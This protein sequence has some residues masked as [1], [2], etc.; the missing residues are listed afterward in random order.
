M[1]WT[2]RKKSNSRG[3]PSDC[4]IDSDIQEMYFQYEKRLSLSLSA[5]EKV[6]QS[7]DVFTIKVWPLSLR[8]LCYL[9]KTTGVSNGIN[10]KMF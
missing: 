10:K 3:K 9:L 1:K 5:T 7:L 6:E 2:F 8:Y 4:L